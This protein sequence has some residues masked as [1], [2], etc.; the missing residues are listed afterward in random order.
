MVVSTQEAVPMTR[1]SHY[2]NNGSGSCGEEALPDFDPL[3]LELMALVFTTVSGSGH[4]GLISVVLIMLPNRLNV[5][6]TSGPQDSEKMFNLHRLLMLQ[7]ML[8]TLTRCGAS[9]SALPLINCLRKFVS[10]C[11]TLLGMFPP[12]HTNLD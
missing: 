3:P 8:P 5:A 9:M 6:S 2:T 4:Y 11:M 7:S 12:H 1:R 10:I